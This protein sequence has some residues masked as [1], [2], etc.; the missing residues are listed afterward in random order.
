MVDV[1]HE[2]H[3][4]IPDLIVADGWKASTIR[5]AQCMFKVE[6]LTPHIGMQGFIQ[7]FSTGG[8]NGITI[9]VCVACPY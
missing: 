9:A 7:D 5:E 6:S 4:S 1:T 2:M 8:R 3:C